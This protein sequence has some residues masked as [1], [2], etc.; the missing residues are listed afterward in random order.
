[1]QLLKKYLRFGEDKIFRDY[2]I[3]QWIMKKINL[4]YF[5]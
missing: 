1:M 4:N 5:N 2:M 3:K